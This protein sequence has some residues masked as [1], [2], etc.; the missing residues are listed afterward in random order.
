[1]PGDQIV[2]PDTG[3]LP[4]AS[5]EWREVDSDMGRFRQRWM[6]GAFGDRTNLV[7]VTHYRVLREA[8]NEHGDVPERTILLAVVIDVGLSSR[9]EKAG[10]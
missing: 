1:M 2:L 5:N 10:K 7:G 4:D 6:P 3:Y 9:V 8:W